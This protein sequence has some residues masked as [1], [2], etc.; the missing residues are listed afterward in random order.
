MARIAV[1]G[2]RV[3]VEGY[4]LAGAMVL[5]A[6]TPEEVGAA[7]A[8]LPPEVAVVVLTPDAAACLEGEQAGG[9]GVLTVVMP[10]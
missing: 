6:D 5:P 3:R 2:E 10:S 1:L 4:E 8:A 7:W 9:P